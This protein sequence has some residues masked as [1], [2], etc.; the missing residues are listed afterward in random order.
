MR[1]AIRQPARQCG[2]VVEAALVERLIA[3]TEGQPGLL[4]FLQ[5]ALVGLWDRLA[6]RLLSLEAYDGMNADGAAGSGVVNSIRRESEAALAEIASLH[7][8]GERAVR[9]I[10]VRLVQF[11]EGAPNT[12]RQVEVEEL[13]AAVGDATVFDSVYNILVSHRL[14]TPASRHRSSDHDSKPRPRQRP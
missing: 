4:P 1:E 6:W 5:E 13:A 2:V 11:G 12:R 10:M 8:D 9:T 3:E 14:L 7:P